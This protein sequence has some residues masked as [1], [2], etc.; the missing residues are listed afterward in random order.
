[1]VLSSTKA[2]YNAATLATQESIWLKRLIK[3]VFLPFEEPVE[4][5]C[6]NLSAIRLASYP[7]FHARTKHIEVHYHFVCD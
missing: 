2:E 3:D 4:I 5:E 6:D 7:I 1:M